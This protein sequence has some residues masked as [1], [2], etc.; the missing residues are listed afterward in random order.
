MLVIE[1]LKWMWT[2][3]ISHFFSS[4]L[5]LTIEDTIL[6]SFPFEIDRFTFITLECF[7]SF[8]LFFSSFF[9]LIPRVFTSRLM[10]N[11]SVIP[12][13]EDKRFFT[14]RDYDWLS[15]DID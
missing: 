2:G 14:L 15:N 7:S 12:P 13:E 1:F 3:I 6:F 5:N 9:F 10:T 8:V 11:L 4:F